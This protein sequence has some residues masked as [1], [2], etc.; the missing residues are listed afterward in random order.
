[1]KQ[2]GIFTLASDPAAIPCPVDAEAQPDRINFLT[3]RLLL[4]PLRQFRER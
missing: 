1:M 3:H 4:K 2:S